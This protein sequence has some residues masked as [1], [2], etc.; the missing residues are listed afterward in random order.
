[1][2]F[3][4]ASHPENPMSI[5]VRSLLAANGQAQIASAYNEAGSRKGKYAD[6]AGRG[7]RQLLPAGTPKRVES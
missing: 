1:M 6:G 2:I 7:M 5:A 3:P 4:G